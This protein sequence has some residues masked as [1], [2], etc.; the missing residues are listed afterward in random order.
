MRAA[1]A[2]SEMG[3]AHCGVPTLEEDTYAVLRAEDL[4]LRI[5]Q[6]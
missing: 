6:A 2:V 3:V 5:Q 4:T 1:W